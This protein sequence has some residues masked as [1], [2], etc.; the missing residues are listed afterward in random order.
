MMPRVGKELGAHIGTAAPDTWERLRAVSDQ[1]TCEV[2]QAASLMEIKQY[3]SRRVPFKVD[4]VQHGC[5]M[6][7]SAT[8]V[9][10]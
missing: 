1:E 8:N 6:E 2:G 4:G 3:G 9:V 5:E 10:K 7:C